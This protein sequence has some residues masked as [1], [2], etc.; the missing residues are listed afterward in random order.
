M[1]V[2]YDLVV[3]ALII[4]INNGIY[5]IILHK[6]AIFENIMNLKLYS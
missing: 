2:G 5:T 4:F 1:Q 6:I 3:N